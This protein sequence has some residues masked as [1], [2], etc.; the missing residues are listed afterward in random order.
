MYGLVLVCFD[1]SKTQADEFN[2]W[3]D[4]EH[5]PERERTRIMLKAVRWL[6]RPNRT[7]S[8]AAYDLESVESLRG[9]EY[10]AI[11]GD[12]QSPWSKRMLR[13]CTLLFR[14]EGRQLY[15]GTA[16][17]DDRAKAMLMA[18]VDAPVAKEA[19]PDIAERMARVPGVVSARIYEGTNDSV[20]FLEL[21]ELESAEVAGSDAWER[22][23][24][25][26]ADRVGSQRSRAKLLRLCD[27]Y[28][29]Q[30]REER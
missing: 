22:A 28:V 5:I 27:R 2:D 13:M 16:L 4:T 15:P 9:P 17:A 19:Y 14:F 25:E 18:G 23:S 3:Y 10:L 12:N 26:I 20:R 7:I 8:V 1:Y 24:V 11:T 30:G 29:R 21:Y 6:D